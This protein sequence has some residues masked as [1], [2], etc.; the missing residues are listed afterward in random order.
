MFEL[1]PLDFQI[2][3]DY[4]EKLNGDVILFG[5]HYNSTFEDA[6]LTQGNSINAKKA[7]Y[8]QWLL[9][10]M[11]NP[12]EQHM[13]EVKPNHFKIDA[14]AAVKYGNPVNLTMLIIKKKLALYNCNQVISYEIA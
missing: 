14:R 2:M 11:E 5:S 7:N 10:C 4:Q 6:F 13:V 8:I 9:G 3:K 1:S 12:L